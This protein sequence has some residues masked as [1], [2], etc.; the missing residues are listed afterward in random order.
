MSKVD[1]YVKRR[2]WDSD[3]KRTIVAES[4]IEGVSATARRH[5]LQTHQIYNWRRVLAEQNEDEYRR[6]PACRFAP[7]TMPRCRLRR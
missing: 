5:S 4:Y 3:E 6:R 1:V 2:R 7:V